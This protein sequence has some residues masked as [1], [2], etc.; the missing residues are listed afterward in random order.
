[1]SEQ[2]TMEGQFY[3][4]YSEGTGS[5]MYRPVL[6]PLYHASAL[7][8][9]MEEN[10]RL[11]AEIEYLKIEAEGFDNAKR[12][13]AGRLGCADEPR[14]KWMSLGLTRLIER[15]VAAE[16]RAQ[17]AEQKLEKA[18]EFLKLYRTKTPIGHQPH[19][20]VGYV[21]AFI[22]EAGE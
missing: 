12:E 2:K 11:K 22:K 9:L 16:A 21:D 20:M 1:M 13:L 6:E 15:A 5:A 4:K 7:T 19:L 17:A 8:S 14:W 3:V 10:E 18:V